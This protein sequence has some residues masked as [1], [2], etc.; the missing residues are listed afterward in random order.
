M[1]TR[2]QQSWTGNHQ[3]EGGLG[4][5][6][7]RAGSITRGHASART[8]SRILNREARNRALIRSSPSRRRVGRDLT[9]ATRAC[10]QRGRVRDWPAPGRPHPRRSPPAVR[11]CA[12]AS[13]TS[14]TMAP[15]RSSL[16]TRLKFT[17]GGCRPAGAC[18]SA[19]TDPFMT[20]TGTSAPVGTDAGSPLSI[21]VTDSCRTRARAATHDLAS[22]RV[23]FRK[24]MLYP[25]SY[26]GLLAASTCVAGPCRRAVPQRCMQPSHAGP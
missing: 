8:P 18:R 12:A 17:S 4:Q 7:T 3:P 19:G 14:R 9:R 1:F 22:A 20:S 15:S 26:E 2:P 5:R 21:A 23:R 10:W 25:L 16:T 13:W 6:E 11:H 24:P